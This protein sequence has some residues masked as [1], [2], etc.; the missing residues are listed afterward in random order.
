MKGLLTYDRYGDDGTWS[1]V[2]IRLGS[3]QQWLDVLVNTVSSE[4][5]VP[6]AGSCIANGQC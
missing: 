3:P 1:A 2:S 5:W 4:T 6:G